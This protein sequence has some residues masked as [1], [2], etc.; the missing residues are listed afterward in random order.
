M[1]HLDDKVHYLE[2]SL[3]LIIPD[4]FRLSQ[5][6][7]ACMVK[8]KFLA[9]FPVNHLPHPAVI[10]FYRFPPLSYCFV[11][12]FCWINSIVINDIIHMK[13]YNYLKYLEPCNTWTLCFNNSH[14]E[15]FIN[16]YYYY[17][18]YYYYYYYYYLFHEIIQ[19]VKE[20]W[21]HN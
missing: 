5:M 9:Q 15:V 11:F 1:V 13:P 14:L 10:I 7:F 17:H 21:V 3:R 6:P 20:N 12:F 16:Y 18:Y 4:G 8:F 2:T 19:L